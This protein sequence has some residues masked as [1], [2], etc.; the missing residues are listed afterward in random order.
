MTGKLSWYEDNKDFY[1]NYEKR[2]KKSQRTAYLIETA[3]E[4]CLDGDKVRAGDMVN[5]SIGQGDV[6]SSTSSKD[7][8]LKLAS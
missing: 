5:F 7:H 6:L 4:N 3:R 8:I 1:C 2:A